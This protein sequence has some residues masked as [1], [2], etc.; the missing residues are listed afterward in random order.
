QVNSNKPSARLGGRLIFV[1]K[2]SAT[3]K[4]LK[5]DLVTCFWTLL[6][7]SLKGDKKG[8][9]KAQALIHRQPECLF[10][11]AFS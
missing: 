1:H 5:H 4:P 6:G 8:T 3:A 11:A 7:S 10:A 9:K 2:S